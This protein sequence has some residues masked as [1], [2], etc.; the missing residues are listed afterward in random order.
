M[1]QNLIDLTFTEEQLRAIDGAIAMLDANLAGL[2]ALTPK[3]R[4]EVH[5]MGTANDPFCRRVLWVLAQ[6][7][8]IVPPSLSVG[9]ANADIE[10]L[11][12]LRLRGIRLKQ[13]LRRVQD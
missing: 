8:R 10:A 1:A 9:D 13:L 6:T 2:I 7:P 12:Q 11:D 5:K 4:H 3:L